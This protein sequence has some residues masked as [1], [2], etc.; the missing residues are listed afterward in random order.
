VNVC[1]FYEA[2]HFIVHVAHCVRLWSYVNQS[3]WWFTCVR[4]EYFHQMIH[5]MTLYFWLMNLDST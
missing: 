5:S 3:C 2:V 1:A 4:G